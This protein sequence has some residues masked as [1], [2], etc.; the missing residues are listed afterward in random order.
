VD[1]SLVTLGPSDADIAA[2]ML[3]QGT[4]KLPVPGNTT[5]LGS[6]RGQ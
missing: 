6:V 1:R 5:F 3:R 4:E 2:A